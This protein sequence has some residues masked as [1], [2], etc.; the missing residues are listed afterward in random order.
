MEQ[1]AGS[2]EL[3]KNKVRSHCLP[4]EV[5]AHGRQRGLFAPYLRRTIPHDSEAAECTSVHF[6][7]FALKF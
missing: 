2:R 4:A 1:G 5:R 6:V 7:C 3:E